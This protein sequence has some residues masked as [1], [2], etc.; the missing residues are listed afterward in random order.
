MAAAQYYEQIQKAYIAYYGR[1]A[2][3]AGQDYWATQL[4][5]AGG[6]LNVIINAFGNSAESTHLYGGSNTAAQVNA[7]YQTLFGRDADSAGLSFYVQGINNGTFSLASVALNIYNGATGNDATELSAKLSYADAFTAAIGQS[8]AA[9]VAYSGD[10]A[11]NNARAALAE[12]VDT[13]SE[14]T[15]SAKLPA[16]VGNIGNGTVGQTVTLTT[17][18][19]GVNVTGGNAVINALLATND[20]TLN[21]FDSIKAQGANNTL[22]I[23]DQGVG[24]LPVITVSG[25]QT[26]NVQSTIGETIDASGWTG[27]TALNIATSKGSDVVTAAAT[28]AVTVND[29]VGAGNTV[30]V[31]G[32]ST[33]TI[34]DTVAAAAAAGQV[35]VN[36]VAGTTSV[37]VA[38]TLGAA[39]TA[40]KVVVTDANESGAANTTKADTI[41]TVSLDGYGAGSKILS[42]ALTNL[43]LANSAVDVTVTDNLAKPTATTLNL[44]VNNLAT[45]AS[46][47]DTNDEITTLNVTTTGK[48]SELAVTDSGLKTL[49]VSGTNVLTFDATVNSLKNVTVSGSAGLSA[50]LSGDTNLADVNASATSGNNTVNLGSVAATYE[51]G[52]GADVVTLSAIPTVA[53]DGGAGVNTL[54]LDSIADLSTLTATALAHATNFQVLELTGAVGATNGTLDLSALPSSFNSSIVID[55]T[56]ANNLT[57]N[58]AAAT[59]SLTYGSDLTEN[60]TVNLKAA[61]SA[62]VLNLTLGTAKSTALLDASGKLTTA[63]GFETVNV[64]TLGDTT[65]GAFTDKLALHDTGATKLVVSGAAGLDLSV[66]S[67]LGS[68]T[69]IDSTGVASGELVKIGAGATSA[70]GASVNVGAADFTFSGNADATH[71]DSITASDGVLSITGS[72]G[73]T[74]VTAG[75]GAADSVN[76]SAS[77]LNNSVTLG[78]GAGDV[79]TAGNGNNTIVVGNGAADVV[80]VGNGNNTITVGNGGDTITVGSGLNVVNGGTGNDTLIISS[81]NTNGNIYTTFNGAHAGDTI[82]FG[83]AVAPAALANAGTVALASTAAFTDFLNAAAAKAGAAATAD[84][85]ASEVAS[86]QYQGNTYVV[87]AAAGDTGFSGTDTVVKLTGTVDLSHI[88]FQA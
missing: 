72:A 74:V 64:A 26:V 36:G 65:G 3:P 38:Q 23:V 67:T 53:I 73:T 11:S 83:T 79:V 75:N 85:A 70:S 77:N 48:D 27:L 56:S 63:D 86:F 76:L 50:N 69:S 81:A 78:N 20:S 9:Q 82:Q 49:A 41:S 43:T 2:D 52:S 60:V 46:L 31:N 28:T 61:G 12:V 57:L 30:V 40:G 1:P 59:T 39:A 24:A 8:T 37:S 47:V 17:G 35:S 13:A 22:N 42:N 66:G 58:K 4:D 62:D 6:N 71:T 18:V 34:H 29:S 45:G 7:I 88:H 51:G 15:A 55:A 21:A 19:D 44:T 87:H 80:T 32:G 68:L 84:A 14:A 54:A 10:A 33:V 5:K 16:T 25:V